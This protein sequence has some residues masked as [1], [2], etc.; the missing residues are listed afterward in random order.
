MQVLEAVLIISDP[1]ARIA[2]TLLLS[3]APRQE[4]RSRGMDMEHKML[5]DEKCRSPRPEAIQPTDVDILLIS[6]SAVC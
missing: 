3:E 6:S 4:P 1:I 2:A 5:R